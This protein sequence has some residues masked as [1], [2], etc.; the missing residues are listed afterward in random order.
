VW[1]DLNSIRRNHFKRLFR[2][3][4]GIT[5]G[6]MT[7][8]AFVTYA[9][10]PHLYDDD[11]L[12]ADVLRGRGVEV[13]AVLWD[14]AQVRWEEFDAVVL[15][16]CWEYHLRTEEFL[17]WITL[18]EMR[19]V[20][21][22]NPPGV[23]RDNA[24]KR[25]LKQLAAEGV[26]VPPTVWLEPGADFDL[27]SITEGQG[28]QQAVIKPVVSMS[29]Y[30]TWITNP[31]RAAADTAAVREMLARSGVMI[32]RFV[33]EVRTRGEWSFVFFMKDYSHAVLKT[34]K[35]GDFRVQ[36]D[37]GGCVADFDPPPRLI[38]QAQR[39]V[40]G[41]KEPLLYA[42]VDA[43]EVDGKLT[44]MELELIDPVL[45]LGRNPGAAARFSDAIEKLAHRDDL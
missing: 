6:A 17:D 25:Y 10:L 12:A 28:W 45:F 20:R 9:E 15:R 11:R 2:R 29:A 41:V 13:E 38:E 34:P 4:G 18:M 32:Q 42:R 39:I 44:L 16:S 23:I 27:I 8:V 26:A 37:F 35:P 43:V 31:A 24:D 7:R 22:W 30:K 5:G 14:C 1:F 21:L 19:A 3:D 36:Q 40:R 33:P